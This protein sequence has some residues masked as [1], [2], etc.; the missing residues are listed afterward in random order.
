MNS[1]ERLILDQVSQMV[2]LVV[3]AD[4]SIRY[5]N[6]TALAHLGY[7]EADLTGKSITDIE[8]ALSDVFYWQ[9]V[10][11]GQLA[12]IEAQE[13]LYLCFD[14]SLLP[15][16]KSVRV[17]HHEGADLLLVQAK[18]IRHERQVEDDLAQT[19]SRLRATLE[20]T[21][22]GILVLDL[23][24]HVTAMNRL[25]AQMWRIPDELLVDDDAK[26][27]DFIAGCVVDVDSFR[28]RLAGIV[29]MDE[30]SDVIKLRDRRVFECTSRPQYLGERTI[31]RVFGF[32]DITERM[33]IEER[34]KSAANT[35]QSASRAKTD[36][37]AM[38]SHEIRT[39]IN[40]VMGMVALMLDTSLDAEQRRYLDSINSCS[41][42]LLSI[43][44]DILDFSKIESHKLALERIDFNLLT[45]LE[46]VSDLYALRAAEKDI[47]Y[48]MHLDAEVPVA[49][50]GDPGRV[51]QI[52][53]NLIGNAIKFTPSGTIAV[54]VGCD[55]QSGDRATLRIAV[56]DTGIGIAADRLDRI[57]QR[58]EQADSSTTRKYGGTGLGLAIT[59]QLV[60]L[61]G[62][63][64]SVTS[65][66]GS[67]STF[68]LTLVVERQAQ[69]AAAEP[70]P[71]LERLPELKGVRAL[72]VDD[73]ATS[74]SHLADLL[75]QWGLAADSAGD[76]ESALARIAAQRQG[77]AP[78]RCVLIDMGLPGTD[79]EAL[80][81]AIR[82]QPA[83]A[84][85][86][87]II[88]TSAGYRGDARHFE[89]VGFSA[90]LRKPIRRALLL[91]CLLTVLLGTSAAPAAIVTG[92]SLAESGRRKARLLVV[93]DHAVNLMVMQGVLR[94]L[95][96]DHIETANDG[97][98]AVAVAGKAPFDLI[99]MDCQMPRMDGYEA[100]RQLRAT[101]LRTPIVALTAHAMAGDREKCLEAGMDDY[102]TKPV[103]VDRL[104]QTLDKWLTSPASLG[105]EE[106][107]PAATA[108]TAADAFKYE[109]LLELTMGDKDLAGTVLRMFA[110]NLP[111]DIVKLKNAIAAADAKQVH[112]AAHFIKGGAANI[113]ANEVRAVAAEIERVGGQGDFAAAATLVAEL[114]AKF[115]AFLKHPRVVDILGAR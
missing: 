89:E 57:F 45:L 42:A 37:L 31:G 90:Y 59:K 27:L 5:A 114:E 2:L 39:P 54:H 86:A 99:L 22:N 13:G 9:D 16:R 82:N 103:L 1:L 106:V 17:L 58:F 88:F 18:D 20:S 91:D 52:L 115:Q 79:G 109:Q 72:V 80:G 62:G 110:D 6:R 25:F 68:E 85:T 24:G 12:D 75:T 94:K 43:I 108:P 113:F 101:G 81:Q 21:G 47:E 7:G 71:G 15:V 36:F 8:S 92:H 23:Q 55:D 100:T 14:G 56:S 112:G 96:Y 64:I 38:M 29:G 78:F 30:T 35:A 97:V 32:S 60:E 51:R 53:T 107:K 77:G 10:A 48:T 44:N 33:R 34:L 28:Q 105:L 98:E 40:G 74:R 3:P 46:D 19:M 83:E 84:G 61:M 11:N 93:E 111:A 76:A 73:N 66:E 67:G 69:P 102:L 70:T 50:R 65:E 41:E 87:L 26:V 104:S 95:G 49:L 63:Q 4:L